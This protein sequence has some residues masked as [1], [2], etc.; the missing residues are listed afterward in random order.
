[1]A[2]PASSVGW[3]T[4]PIVTVADGT[5]PPRRVDNLDPK[6]LLP[7]RRMGKKASHEQWQQKTESVR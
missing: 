4:A 2:T 1:M 3:F 6:A 5:G 7:N